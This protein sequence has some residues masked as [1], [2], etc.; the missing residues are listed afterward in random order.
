M[1][2]SDA[3]CILLHEYFKT[4]YHKKIKILMDKL[5]RDRQY[6]KF[7]AYGFFKNLRFFDIFFLLFLKE[8]GLTYTSIGILYSI[9]Q[10]VINLMEVPSGLLADSFGKKRA[11]LFAFGSYIISFVLFYLNQHFLVLSVAMVFYGF[12]EAF[13]SG[14]HKAIILDYLKNKDLLDHK[15][16]YYGS[17][18]SW[19]QLGSALVALLSAGF[20]FW[21][22]DYRTLFVLTL[23]PYLIDL[24]II[25]SYPQDHPQGMSY[26]PRRIGRAFLGTM[27]NFINLFHSPRTVRTLFSAAVY[28]A[29]FKTVKDYLQPLLKTAALQ[30]PFLMMLNTNKR[31]ALLF[32]LVYFTLFLLTSM[33][34]KNAWRLEGTKKDTA[35]PVNYLFIAGVGGVGLSGLAV[36]LGLPLLAV[37]L[38]ILLYLVQNARRPLMLSLL[39]ERIDSK[40]MASGLSAESQMETLLVAIFA[41]ILG[42]L[43]DHFGLSG[44]LLSIG[45]G[46]IVLFPLIRLR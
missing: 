32:G 14:T 18:R 42:M 1:F 10:I 19:S 26:S 21:G 22:T 3:V 5:K 24:G 16:Q 30:L 11:L 45:A 33:V 34:S 25:S 38:F 39:S 20:V 41:P 35:M 44:G 12:G 8:V 36:Y 17:T 29:F 46:F 31:S 40:I 15:S 6:Y 27:R 4:L 37:S 9:R 23:I 28:I 43:V 13:R 7:C 2:L